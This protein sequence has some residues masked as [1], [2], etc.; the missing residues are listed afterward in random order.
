LQLGEVHLNA[1][2]VCADELVPMR[3]G[4]IPAWWAKSLKELFRRYLYD[5]LGLAKIVGQPLYQDSLIRTHG[6][7]CEGRWT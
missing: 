5:K 1:W 4:L 7:N 2:Q 6:P 3:W